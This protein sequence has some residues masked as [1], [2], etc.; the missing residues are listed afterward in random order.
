MFDETNDEEYVYKL[1]CMNGGNKK[2]FIPDDDDGEYDNPDDHDG[3][4]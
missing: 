3:D 4:E 2:V 1:E